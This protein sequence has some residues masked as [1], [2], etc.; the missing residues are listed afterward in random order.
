MTDNERRNS[1]R[2]PFL[3]D[4]LLHQG[5]QKWR[6]ELV[7]ISLKGALITS[8]KD[9]KAKLSDN[10][11]IE[12]VLGEGATLN[13]QTSISHIQDGRWGL[14]WED[15]DIECF[16]HLRRLLELNTQDPNVVHRE[17]EDLG[18]ETEN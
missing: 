15:I 2:I 14:K 5:D 6:C 17:L 1:H 10:Y 13:M 11:S 3:A 4:V 9:I 18:S 16:I 8:P 12:L 7:D